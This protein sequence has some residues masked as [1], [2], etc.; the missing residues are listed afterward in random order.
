MML[1]CC[2]PDIPEDVVGILGRMMAKDP[3]RRY[4][5]PAHLAAHLRALARKL[6]I[7][8]GSVPAA[9]AADGRYI[10][11]PLV[12]CAFILAAGVALLISE[13][14]APSPAPQN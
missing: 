14:R 12:V 9:P 13:R 8:A 4:Q 7:P 3:D 6:G 2:H 11:P 1:S 5:D 10:F